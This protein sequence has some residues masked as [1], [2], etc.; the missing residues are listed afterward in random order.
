MEASIANMSE[1]KTRAR[2]NLEGAAMNGRIVKSE[3]KERTEESSHGLV[4]IACVVVTV[5]VERNG[6]KARTQHIVEVEDAPEWQ[7]GGTA[8]VDVQVKQLELLNTR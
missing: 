7:L 6:F 3:L 8:S 4:T 5:E 2:Y 1:A